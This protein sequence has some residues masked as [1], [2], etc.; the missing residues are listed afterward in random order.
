MFFSIPTYVF[1]VIPVL[2]ILIFALV[3][4]IV[5]SRTIRIAKNVLKRVDNAQAEMSQLMSDVEMLQDYM[6]E[7]IKALEKI[8]EIIAL[9]SSKNTTIN[10]RENQKR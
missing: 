8:E 9:E 7:I 1:T 10:P 5:F 2:S 4:I 3:W 6:D